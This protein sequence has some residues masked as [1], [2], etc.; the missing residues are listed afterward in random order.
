[1]FSAIQRRS[2]LLFL[3][4]LSHGDLRER[5][6]NQPT[7]PH[8]VV[9]LNG[10]DAGIDQRQWD[11]AHATE[12][13]LST[14]GNALDQIEGVP[15]SRASAEYW[16]RLGKRIDTIEDLILCYY[17]TFKVVRVPT[18][19]QYTLIDEQIGKLHVAIRAACESSHQ[20]K[21]RARLLIGAEELGDYLQSGFDHFVT[22]LDVPFNFMQVS[23]AQNPIR[24]DFGGHVLHLCQILSSRIPSW[25]PAEMQWMLGQLS[26]V[27]ASCVLLDCA[28]FRKGQLDR[29]FQNYVGFFEYAVT[30]YLQ[31][32]CSCSFV[33]P[34]GL[35]MC[36]SVRARHQI[37]GHQD[38]HGII[39]VGDYVSPFAEDF[40]K[41][42]IESL[43]IEIGKL[44]VSFS[45][46]VEQVAR[47]KGGKIL[48][49]E[50]IAFAFHSTNLCQFYR[51]L[52][53]STIRSNST[54][55]C[56]VMNT[57]Q[58]PLPCGHVLCD[59]CVRVCGHL[60]GTVLRVS[61]CPLHREFV[62]WPQPKIIRYKP[63]EAGVRILALDGGGIRGAVQ[64]EILRGIEQ[65]IGNRL[66]VQAFFGV[67][68]GTG[69]GGLIAT[70][71]AHRNT[72]L[73]HA[74]AQFATICKSAYTAKNP[75]QGVRSHLMRAFG[76]RP[77]YKSSRLCDVLKREFTEALYFFGSSDQFRPETK[78]AVVTS[79]PTRNKT[80]LV[81]NYRR[82]GDESS[83]YDFERPQNP[84]MELKMWQ[85]VALYATMAEPQH[86]AA[87]RLGKCFSGGGSTWAN[88]SSL[89][90]MEARKIWPDT[91][92]PDIL[93]SLGTGQDRKA[94]L[95]ELTSEAI[96]T[97]S[98]DNTASL[99]GVLRKV[100][101]S[102]KWLLP[103]HK[104]VLDAERAWRDFTTA[105]PQKSPQRVTRRC[106][107]LNIDFG[108]EEPPT[109]DRE[110]QVRRISTLASDNVQE[111]SFQA[112]LRNVAY[113]LVATSFF[114]RVESRCE[115]AI[116]GRIWCRFAEHS[117]EVK[118]LGLVLGDRARGGFQPFFTT[119]AVP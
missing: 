107:R 39:A 53:P 75:C 14:V 42:W 27:L 12:S 85:A 22:H 91:V 77:R 64:L 97:S 18:G 113:R 76:S 102:S 108:Q 70:S 20:A 6:V 7:L 34:D 60:S 4:N 21:R 88:P 73:D 31:L 1:M 30:E 40:A 106:F 109:Q 95:A 110:S 17:A 83:T 19:P 99:R 54:C 69:T 74:C 11:S 55:L 111:T 84:T 79:D 32:H 49:E 24:Q 50:S 67:M 98:T 104:D 37:K 57:P 58:H 61:W 86:F 80:R 115:N 105:D 28:R 92:E 51:S 38:E 62:H 101:K 45:G 112:A 36:K 10:S 26:A 90:F 93:L 47:S 35:R 81:G 100:Q 16:Q 46:D 59:W 118:G 56:C 117:D 44:H 33:S 25:E 8:C 5:S 94:I 63:P 68:V 65:A 9:V 114:F 48:S 15:Q 3:R 119:L 66:P 103:G 41:Q 13:L 72:S 87:L 2:L 96:D 89:A 52:G 82:K 29:L 43:R 78:V 23:L 116:S 71:L